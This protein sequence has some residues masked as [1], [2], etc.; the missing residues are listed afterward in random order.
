MLEEKAMLPLTS[1]DSRPAEKKSRMVDRSVYVWNKPRPHVGQV[2]SSRV[3]GGSAVGLPISSH[4][5]L[6]TQP[7]RD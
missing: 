7:S 2:P 6:E 4:P 3:N 1:E 5:V